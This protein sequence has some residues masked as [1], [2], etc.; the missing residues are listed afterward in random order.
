MALCVAVSGSSLQ[1]AG[2]YTTDC[3]GYALMTAT[4]YADTPT[5]AALFAQPD[6]EA[7]QSAFSA[8]LSLPLILW[9]VSWGFGVVVNFIN[10]RHNTS[11]HIED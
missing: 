9:L 6:A 1:V 5:L 4:E 3:A 2:E 11:Q 7:I 10:E 8:G